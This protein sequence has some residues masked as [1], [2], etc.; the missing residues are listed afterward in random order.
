MTEDGNPDAHHSEKLMFA[1]VG[2]Q[3]LTATLVAVA[4]VIVE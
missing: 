4:L 1:R 3:A 2:L